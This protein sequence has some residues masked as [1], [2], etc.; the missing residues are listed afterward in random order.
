MLDVAERNQTVSTDTRI[1]YTVT[2]DVHS[3]AYRYLH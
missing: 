2:I 3:T 1:L